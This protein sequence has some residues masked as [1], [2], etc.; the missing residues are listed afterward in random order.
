MNYSNDGLTLTEQF[1]GCKQ[2]AYQ[3]Q[4]GVWTIGYGHTKGVTPSMTCTKEQ[5]E[6]WLRQDV[7]EAEEAVIELVK[8]QL[9]QNQFDAL[10]DFVF[11]LGRGN[12]SGSTLL[13]KINASDFKGASSEFEKWN[14]AGG[15]VRSGLT[16]RRFAER[17]L[18]LQ[19]A[20]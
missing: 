17:D 8:V 6:W 4:K 2:K 1:E 16:R 18:F 19:G 20:T 3:D 7:E 5:A 13:K 14:R 12:F 10:V 15:I 11:N 9:R